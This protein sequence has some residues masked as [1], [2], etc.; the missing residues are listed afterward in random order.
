L[1]A[2]PDNVLRTAVGQTVAIESSRGWRIGKEKQSH[3]IDVVVALAMACLAAVREQRHRELRQYLPLGADG[4]G[5]LVEVDPNTG[6]RLERPRTRLLCDADG[7][8]KL[9]NGDNS[10]WTSEKVSRHDVRKLY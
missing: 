7:N 9:V 5:T 10:C 6:R 3:R 2:Y 4:F 1:V 8:L